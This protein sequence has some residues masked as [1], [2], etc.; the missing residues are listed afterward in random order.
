MDGDNVPHHQA[1]AHR[2]VPERGGDHG[3]GHH[4]GTRAADE[5]EPADAAR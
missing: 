3:S 2:E 1:E 4:T 5:H